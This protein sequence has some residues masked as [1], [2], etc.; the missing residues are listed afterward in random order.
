METYLDLNTINLLGRVDTRIRK[1]D[2][3]R[4][5]CSDY[6]LGRL[7]SFRQ[8]HEGF[9]DYN[10][11]LTTTKGTFLLKLFS[12][13]KSFRHVKDNIQGLIAFH[14]A[15]VLV[16]RILRNTKGET[17]FS[18]EEDGAMALGCLM[19]YFNGTS[20]FKKGVEPTLEQM[21][22]IAGEMEK[23]NFCGFKPKGIYDV[24]VVQN[25]QQEF[26]KKGRFLSTDD[27]ERCKR[28]VK[29]LRG[30]NI[31]ACTKGTIHND[32]QRSNVLV[33][34]VGEIRIIDFSVMEYGAIAI[35]LA[36]FLALFCINPLKTNHIAAAIIIKEVISFYTSKRKLTPC[37]IASIPPLMLGTY[38][39]NNLAATFE[40][41]G[42]ENDS[43]E[44]RYW[45]KL[46]REGMKMM[47]KVVGRSK[48]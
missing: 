46:G 38:A 8:I 32:I 3:V 31:S 28:A 19:E 29:E 16:P 41:K 18:N 5:V 34:R 33:N 12:Q 45:I 23:I 7:L 22:S 9:E 30:V 43:E 13:Y 39:A 44:T 47:E 48:K 36:T 10:I 35:D 11:K 37:D 26:E 27:F 17:L 25:L 4:H 20:F 21:K 40:Q 2:L 42:K 1:D 14:D 6:S 15:G 24:W